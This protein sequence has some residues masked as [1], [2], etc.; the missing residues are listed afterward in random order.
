MAPRDMV[1]NSNFRDAVFSKK[2]RI[3][4]HSINLQSFSPYEN[5]RFLFYSVCEGFGRW[6][7]VPIENCPGILHG[8]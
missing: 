6:K 7:K 5:D 3:M 8:C 2:S 1:P 4:S